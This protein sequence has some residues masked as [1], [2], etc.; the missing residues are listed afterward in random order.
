MELNLKICKEM[1]IDLRRNK[2]AIPLTNSENNTV[3]RVTSYKLLALWIDDNMKWNTNT[4]KIVKKA[5]KCLFLLKVLKSYGASTSNMKNFYIAVIRPTLEYGAQV[6]NGGISKDQS[7]QIE[8]I[9]KRALK[10][11]YKEDDYDKC[12]Q[13]AELVSLKHRRDQMCIL[14]QQFRVI[15]DHLTQNA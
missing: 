15:R 1:L 13:T 6:R 3:E 14:L 5:A 12:L 10:I 8:R 11:I 4:E 9:Q 7:N 2:T